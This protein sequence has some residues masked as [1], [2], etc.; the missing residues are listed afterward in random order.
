MSAKI[1]KHKTYIGQH[2]KLDR[3][4]EEILMYF[5]RQEI[6]VGYP[7]SLV[8]GPIGRQGGKFGAGRRGGKA[9]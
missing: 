5:R 9:R 7:K 2:R 4:I 6:H 8:H 1:G 3:V